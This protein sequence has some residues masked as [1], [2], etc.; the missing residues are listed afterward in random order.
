[1]QNDELAEDDLANSTVFRKIYRNMKSLKTLKYS[2]LQAKHLV[3]SRENEKRN[4]D[5]PV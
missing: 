4:K 2:L 5:G 1:M 3:I